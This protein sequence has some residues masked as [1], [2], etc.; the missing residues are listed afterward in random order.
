VA[1]VKDPNAN[2]DYLFDWAD[3]LET[4]DTITSHDVQVASG[5]VVIGTHTNTTTSVTVWVSAGTVNTDATV[6]A[7]VTTAQGRIDDRT[8]TLLIRE[9]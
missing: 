7:R 8:I 9:R 3:W 5:D 4:G 2:L 1:F 6:R